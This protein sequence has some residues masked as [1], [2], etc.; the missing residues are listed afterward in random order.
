MQRTLDAGA[1]INKVFGLYGTYAR[2]LLPVAAAVFV[3]EAVIAAVLIAIAPALVFLA[4]V[5]QLIASTLYQ[6]MVVELVRDVQ[7]GRLDQSPRQMLSS[8]TPVLGMLIG[9]GLIAGIGIAIGFV[10]IIVPGLFLLTM[11]SVVAPVV[12]IERPGVFN[13]LG[14]SRVLVKGNGWPVFGVIVVFF[15]IFFVASLVLGAIG[16]AL[17]EAGRII[18]QIVASELTAPLIALVASVLYFELVGLKG[19]GTAA[20]P[21]GFAPPV[22]EG[23]P[24]IT[25]DAPPP[26]PPPPPPR[27]DIGI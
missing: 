11:W 26:P 1:L 8:V 5:V 24:G 27:P 7:D 12:V 4:L 13:A 25:P 16:A 17:G 23:T 2:V 3:V 18:F 9:A 10:L 19:G 15:V 22:A 14:R 20:T 21:G 6:G